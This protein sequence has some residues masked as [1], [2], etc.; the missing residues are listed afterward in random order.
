MYQNDIY[1]NDTL[2]G[3]ENET[4]DQKIYVTHIVYFV[5]DNDMVFLTVPYNSG[6][7]GTC[8]ER[9]LFC[10]YAYVY[11]FDVSRKSVVRIFMS[12]GRTSGMRTEDK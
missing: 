5:P 10:I 2:K 4:E 1:Q 7:F 3:D 9:K 12:D 11:T 6:I 8:Y